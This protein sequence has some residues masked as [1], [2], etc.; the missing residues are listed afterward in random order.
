[1]RQVHA[2]RFL[3]VL[4][5]LAVM[6]GATRAENIDPD[7]DGS[8]YAWGENVGW[9]NLEPSGDG[10][11]GVQITDFEVNGWMWGEN[12]GW[13]SLSCTNRGTCGQVPYGISHDG[14]GNL[15]GDAWGENVGWIRFSHSQGNVWIDPA[16]GVMHGYAWGE[17]VGWIKFEPDSY[18]YRVKTAW[19]C[20]PPPPLPT[21]EM[22]L[23]IEKLGGDALRLHWNSVSDATGYDIVHGDLDTLRIAPGGD[24]ALA[25]W[26]CV[27]ENETI[28]EFPVVPSPEDTGSWYLVRPVNCGGSGTYDSGGS[29]QLAPRDLGIEGSSVNCRVP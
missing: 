12:V 18:L 21:E 5:L 10:G 22:Q 3:V 8:Q 29:E 20:S 28:T 1:M 26:G 2:I 14:L 15:F 16:D 27:A 6:P 23:E 7:S 17:N 13:I 25:T 19:R 11:P 9:V 24:F 4:A